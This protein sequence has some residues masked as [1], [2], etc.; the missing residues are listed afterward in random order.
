MQGLFIILQ[1]L[2]FLLLTIVLS[3][4]LELASALNYRMKYKNCKKVLTK[5]GRKVILTKII[6]IIHI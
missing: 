3:Q 1:K 4:M 6:H 2:R 5:S